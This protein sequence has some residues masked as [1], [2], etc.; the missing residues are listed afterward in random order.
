M[1]QTAFTKRSKPALISALALF[2]FSAI[3]FAPAIHAQKIK[4]L[5]PPPPAPIYKPKPT[6]TPAPEEMEVVRITSNLIVV[7]V[8]V[9]DANGQPVLGLSA[10]DFRI[11]ENGRAQQIAQLGDPEQVPLDIALLFDVSS[12][13]REKSLFAFQQTAAATFLKRVLKSADRAAVFT[14]SDQP[15]LVQPLTRATVA[16][17][18]L[19]NVPAPPRNVPTAFY[20]TVSAAAQYLANNSSGRQRRVIVVISD[21][22]DNFSNAIRDLSINEARAASNGQITPE[23]QRVAMQQKHRDAVLEVERAIQKSDITFYSINPNGPS[24][25]LNQIS[26]RAQN[27]MAT[28]ATATGGAAFVPANEADLN[29]IFSRVASEIRSQYLLQYYS[30]NKAGGAAF[31]RIAVTSPTHPDLRVRAREGYFPKH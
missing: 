9:T 23:A 2:F 16:A 24:I 28:I 15:K 26:T 12:S 27:A 30:D 7:P 17:E 3:L 25:R 20:D 8:S 19:M 21:G 5:P 22:D 10:N 4:Q 6:P 31:R 18:T 14:I 13:V 1:N 29:A 11:E